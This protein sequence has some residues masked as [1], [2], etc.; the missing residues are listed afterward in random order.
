MSSTSVRGTGV[1]VHISCL[2]VSHNGPAV[3]DVP[4]RVICSDGTD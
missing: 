2:V 4:G 3:R 1:V